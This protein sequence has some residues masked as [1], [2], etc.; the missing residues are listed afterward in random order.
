[1][2]IFCFLV[3]TLFGTTLVRYLTILTRPLYKQRRFRKYPRPNFAVL[4]YE[5]SLLFYCCIGMYCYKQK[6]L[7]VVTSVFFLVSPVRL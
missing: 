5:F 7:I 6:L 1:M 4:L 3:K 2:N